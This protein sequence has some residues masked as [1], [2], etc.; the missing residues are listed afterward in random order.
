MACKTS[1]LH[2]YPNLSTE[3]VWNLDALD[4]AHGGGIN[5]QCG[6]LFILLGNQY[7][8]WWE[9]LSHC[10]H[11]EFYHQPRLSP[12]KVQNQQPQQNHL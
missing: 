6:G 1:L 3:R 5:N 12:Q 9:N 7:Q 10:H 8:N 2:A 11:L 4:L